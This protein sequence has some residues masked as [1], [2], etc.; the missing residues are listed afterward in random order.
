MGTIL[1]SIRAKLHPSTRHETAIERAVRE[2]RE[3]DLCLRRQGVVVD[4]MRSSGHVMAKAEGDLAKLAAAQRKS[5]DHLRKL[6]A[7]LEDTPDHGPPGLRS[8]HGR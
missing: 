2:V 6:V 7:E 8:G 3:G 5:L 1:E 4:Q